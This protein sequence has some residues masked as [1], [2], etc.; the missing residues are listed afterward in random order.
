MTGNQG[1]HA[2]ANSHQQYDGM[3]TGFVGKEGEYLPMT[4]PKSDFIGAW[5]KVYRKDRKIPL[6]AVAMLA[7][8]DKQQSNWKTMKR[9]MIVKCAE[10]L[11]LRKAFPQE[12]NGLYTQEEMP[13]EFSQEAKKV[14]VKPLLEAKK[15]DEIFKG[16]DVPENWGGSIFNPDEGVKYDLTNAFEGVVEPETSKKLAYLNSQGGVE[17]EPYLWSFPVRVKALEKY[18]FK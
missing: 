7:E 12:F 3:E 14:E 6:E 16:D 4:Y 18:E 11:A 9:I 8:Y 13:V 15:I 10:S 5:A 2:I 1:F 17:L